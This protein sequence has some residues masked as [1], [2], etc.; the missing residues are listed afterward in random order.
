MAAV[1]VGGAK[2]RRRIEIQSCCRRKRSPSDVK[3][4]E[5]GVLVETGIST[6]TQGWGGLIAAPAHPSVHVLDLR[7]RVK[8][9]GI[10]KSLGGRRGR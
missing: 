3:Q 1:G 8:E 7:G 9:G 5:T 10:S 6:G 4:A 2:R